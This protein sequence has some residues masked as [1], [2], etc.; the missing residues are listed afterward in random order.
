[1]LI[2]YERVSK[3]K[4]KSEELPLTPC[5]TRQ[6]DTNRST[7]VF[8]K[9]TMTSKSE[10]NTPSAEIYTGTQLNEMQ[11]YGESTGSIE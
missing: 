1:M 9:N 2:I 7:L 8:V 5:N 11:L 6:Q 3:K 4:C 10:L